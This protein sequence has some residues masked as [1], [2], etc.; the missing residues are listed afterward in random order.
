MS[1]VR[2]ED[3]PEHTTTVAG[4]I[5]EE[6]E[7][8]R[9]NRLIG[10]TEVALKTVAD[11]TGLPL[12]FVALQGNEPVGIARLVKHDMESRED[13]SPWLSA[14]FVPAQHRGSGIGTRL[15]AKIVDEATMVG[16]SAIYLFTRD[17]ES[18][19]TKQGWKV[20]ERTIYREKE[21][22][23]LTMRTGDHG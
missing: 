4:W 10:H 16:F 12:S 6:W 17:R 23:V 1:I 3:V 9:P 13:L 2:L 19:Y 7:R 20:L 18:F 21:V 14:V 22:V 8:H 11:T 15:C 5:Y